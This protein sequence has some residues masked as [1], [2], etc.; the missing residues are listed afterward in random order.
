MGCIH[1]GTNFVGVIPYGG[2]IQSSIPPLYIMIVG[3]VMIMWSGARNQPNIFM[4]PIS[5][6]GGFYNIVSY[7]SDTLSYARILALGLASAII[8]VV[9]NMI[10]A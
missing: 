6:V 7:F 3:A 5:A 10:A 8:G 1:T 2:M 4:K 9:V